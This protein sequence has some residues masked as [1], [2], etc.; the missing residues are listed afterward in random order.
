VPA[1]YGLHGACRGCEHVT[2]L[3]YLR[4][5]QQIIPTGAVLVKASS[6][7]PS[8]NLML[9]G[10]RPWVSRRRR[11]SAASAASA[12]APRPPKASSS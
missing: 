6:G 2:S 10:G 4:P 8:V 1:K 9:G 12:A 7:V 5:M 11:C 3:V